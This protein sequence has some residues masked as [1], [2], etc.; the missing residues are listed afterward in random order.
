MPDPVR[1]SVVLPEL[2]SDADFIGR[3]RPTKENA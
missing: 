2:T 3:S 1:T